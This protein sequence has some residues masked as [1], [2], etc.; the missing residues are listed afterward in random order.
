[1]ELEGPCNNS[2][3]SLVGLAFPRLPWLCCTKPLRV[4]SRIQLLVLSLRLTLVL[5]LHSRLHLPQWVCKPLLG[6][7][8]MVNSDHCGEFLILPFQVSTV[9]F[10]KAPGFPTCK[11]FPSMQKLFLL[12]S[13]LFEMQDLSGFF[14]LSLFFPQCYFPTALCGD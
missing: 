9:S 1:M 11:G 14:S 3:V 7:E 10:P 8:V 12:H 5:S 2:L 4:S 13:S 6:W